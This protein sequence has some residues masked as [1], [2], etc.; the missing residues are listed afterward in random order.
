MTKINI[1]TQKLISHES[2][3]EAIIE[4][5]TPKYMSDISWGYKYNSL[6]IVIDFYQNEDGENIIEQFCEKVKNNWHD[7]TPTDFQI[8]VMFAKLNATP[9]RQVETFTPMPWEDE[10]HE[11]RHKQSDFYS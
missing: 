8:E 7:I 5:L 3:F 4:T 2:Y 6:D 10:M 9:Y 11:N 1:N